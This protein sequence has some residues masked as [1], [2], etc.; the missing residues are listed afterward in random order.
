MNISGIRPYTGFYDN[1]IRIENAQRE[2][3]LQPEVKAEE[4]QQKTDDTAVVYDMKK[5][6]VIQQALSNMKEDRVLEQ[7]Q[8]FAKSASSFDKSLAIMSGENFDL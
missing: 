7:Y 1:S 2:R 6:E 3:A 4:N 5:P 8:F